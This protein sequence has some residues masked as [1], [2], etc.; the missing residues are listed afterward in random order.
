MTPVTIIGGFLGAGKTTLVRRL[1]ANP[2]GRRLGVLVNDFGALNIDAE[3]IGE[4]RPDV[5]SLKNG[6]IC[7]NINSDLAGGVRQLLATERPPDQII[8]ETSGVS[9]P[10][11][12]AETFFSNGVSDRLTVDCILCLIDCLNFPSLTYEETEFAIEQAAVADIVVLNKVDAS[13]RAA[14]KSISKTLRDA[15]PYVR[16]LEAAHADISPEIVFGVDHQRRRRWSAMR[17]V[18]LV[19]GDMQTHDRTFVSWSWQSNRLLSLA[20]FREAV[21]QFPT[22]IYRAKG[23]LFFDDA[24][25]EP[26]LFQLVGKR[27]SLDFQGR[28][29]SIRRNSLVAIGRRDCFDPA[30]MQAIIDSCLLTHQETTQRLQSGLAE[31]SPVR[32]S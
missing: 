30:R 8:I 11:R 5:V 14:I 6:C 15:L 26:G 12:V 31:P 22:S 19:D 21:G 23:A 20:A 10:R 18:G 16:I 13:S 2:E 1:L 17:A 4:I 27:S 28:L 7:C 9:Q 25:G 32:C 3:I 24:P 29:P